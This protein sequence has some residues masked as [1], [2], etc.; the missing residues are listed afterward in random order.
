MSE[1]PVVRVMV[2]VRVRVRTL[3]QVDPRTTDYEQAAV[4]PRR[5]Y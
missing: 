5:E 3:G 2:R 4:P 1:V